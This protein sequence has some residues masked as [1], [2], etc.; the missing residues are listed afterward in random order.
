MCFLLR[1]ERVSFL[2]L[3]L[4][5]EQK[6]VV[7]AASEVA[8]DFDPEYWRNKDKNHEFPEDF[9]KALVDAGFVGIVIPEKYGGGGMGMF[10]MILAMET[11]TSESCGLAGEWFLCLTSVFGGLSILK[12]GNEL[13]KDNYLPRISKGMEFCL[14]LT[15]PDAGSNTLNIQTAAVETGDEY[16]I[17]GR[18]AL[19]SGADR[20]KGMLLVT[21]TTPLEKA[22]KRTLGLSLFLVDLPN[23]AV[24]VTPIEK[25]GINYSNT[26]DVYITDL[27]VP[28]EN[29]LGEKDKGWYLVLDT[30]N[31]ERMS[32]SAAAAG[33]GLLAI[34]KAVEHAKQRK[35]FGA[36]I[37]SYQALQFPLA[38]AKAKIEAAR[39]L[40][41]KAAWLYDR[42]QPCGAEANMAKVV[43]VEAGIQAVYHA[44]QTFGGYGYAV[45]YD[46]ERWWREV[47]LTRL[48]PV[49][50][51]MAL[52]FIGEHVLGL[53][54]SY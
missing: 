34:K 52:S 39:L 35:V 28:R 24:E 9:W 30:L 29:L 25:H 45:D 23:Q 41:Y 47:N 14:G 49:T 18:E 46:V 32:F 43:A 20:A 40:N 38:E 26:C 48:A 44:M 2:D 21:R 33:L 12:H 5:A 15:E 4:T 6:M 51:E 8:K 22:P 1:I 7:K 3:E 11:L 50:H 54:K 37:G 36:P 10:E 53:P 17:N 19:I 42:G 27:R 31:P 13:Q 16:V